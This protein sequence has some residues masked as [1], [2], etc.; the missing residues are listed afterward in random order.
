MTEDEFYE[1]MIDY[2]NKSDEY[3]NFFREQLIFSLAGYWYPDDEIFDNDGEQSSVWLV[4]GNNV[5]FEENE[6]C[7]YDGTE[8]YGFSGRLLKN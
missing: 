2:P 5:D 8:N 7:Q 3:K 4:G 6:W 1:K